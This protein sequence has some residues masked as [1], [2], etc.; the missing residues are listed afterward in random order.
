ML[1]RHPIKMPTLGWPVTGMKRSHRIIGKIKAPSLAL[2]R[3]TQR[4]MEYALGALYLG[5]SNGLVLSER[6]NCLILVFNISYFEQV[7]WVTCDNASNNMTMLDNLAT[8]LNASPVR[9][10]LKQWTVAHFHIRW[11]F[12]LS[13]RPSVNWSTATGALLM[14]STLL[15]RHWYWAIRRQN[16]LILLIQTHMNQSLS[17]ILNV[18]LWVWFGLSQSR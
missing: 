2:H 5:L 16:S 15:R 14:S 17:N 10:G 9:K 18:M 12:F 11:A 4:T 13:R 7:G 8:R 3:W 1:G 6:Y